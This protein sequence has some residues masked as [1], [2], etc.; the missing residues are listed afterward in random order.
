MARW[1]PIPTCSLS[2]G[3][4]PFSCAICHAIGVAGGDAQE[5]HWFNRTDRGMRPCATA[6]RYLP[7]VGVAVLLQLVALVRPLA[8]QP[9]VLA[10]RHLVVAVPQLGKAR[11]FVMLRLEQ[12]P[13]VVRVRR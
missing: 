5:I 3:R 13:V 7:L 12:S 4:R 8:Y 9:E 6:V 1:R 11:L 2:G 10:K